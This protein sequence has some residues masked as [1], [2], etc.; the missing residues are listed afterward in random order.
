MKPDIVFFG[1][2]LPDKF[3]DH[4]RDVLKCDAL[5]VIGTSLGVCI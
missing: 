4:E 5:L 3:W 1:E 2:N